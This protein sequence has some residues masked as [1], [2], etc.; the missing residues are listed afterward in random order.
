MYSGRRN[1]SELK[2]LSQAAWSDLCMMLS[3]VTN[4]RLGMKRQGR[5]ANVRK[6]RK[7]FWNLR[8]FLLKESTKRKRKMQMIR[9]VNSRN[10]W[11]IKSTFSL[12]GKKIWRKQCM[13]KNCKRPIRQKLRKRVAKCSMLSQLQTNSWTHQY[14]NVS[15]THNRSQ[16]DNL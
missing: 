11:T 4:K 15:I 8:C 3:I 7:S 9:R 14:T 6:K 5:N 12:G 2:M 16:S 1:S 13:S 10:S